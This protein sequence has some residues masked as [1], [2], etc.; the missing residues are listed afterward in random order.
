ME[1][2]II[3]NPLLLPD[4]RMLDKHGPPLV[5]WVATIRPLKQAELFL[6]L[7]RSIPEI[8]FQMIGG[9]ALGEE[10]YFT[11]I[12]EA[13]CRIPNLDFLGFIPRDRIEPYFAKASILV[14][15]STTEGFPNTFLEA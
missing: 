3:K 1:S 4:N 7:A 13:A 15:A 14:N 6:E 10:Q 5:L 12:K 9:S 8:K 11:S 2:I